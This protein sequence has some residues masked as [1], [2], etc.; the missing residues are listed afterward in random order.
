MYLSRVPEQANK[1]KMSLT[2]TGLYYTRGSSE[3]LS[4]I[5]LTQKNKPENM[6]M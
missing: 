1:L 2:D 4:T 3:S 6:I 5:T